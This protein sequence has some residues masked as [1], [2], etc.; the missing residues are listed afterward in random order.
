MRA[1]AWAARMAR[2]RPA[3]RGAVAGGG[4]APAVVAAVE[5]TAPV[6]GGMEE[7]A[8]EEV[9]EE[10]A[11]GPAAEAGPRAAAA[12]LEGDPPL[13]GSEIRSRIQHTFCIPIEDTL[14]AREKV[15]P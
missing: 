5:V 6:G 15:Y 1:E 2:G 8:A 7:E 4:A 11:V 12:T 3:G 14:F 9:A 10:A 13:S